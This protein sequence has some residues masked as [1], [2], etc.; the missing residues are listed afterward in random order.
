M[1]V[2][3]LGLVLVASIWAA[4]NTLIAGY[5][6]VN[7]TRDRVITGRTDEGVPLTLPH[8]RIMYRNDWVPM[9]IGLAV[10]SLAFAGFILYLPELADQPENLRAVCYVAS[11]LP[12]GSFLGFF[13]LGLSD[14]RVMRGV[15]AEA[16]AKTKDD[17]AGDDAA[18]AGRSPADLV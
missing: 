11:L 8:R 13:V 18:G 12:F 14:R 6:A 17:V 16:E 9:K 1:S 15:L 7:A 5:T 10:A 4:M 2:L 3:Q